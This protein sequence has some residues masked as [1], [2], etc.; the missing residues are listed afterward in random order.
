MYL[1]I[2]ILT[3]H[4]FAGDVERPSCQLQM[5]AKSQL[6]PAVCHST[7]AHSQDCMLYQILLCFSLL[8]RS[9]SCVPLKSAHHVMGLVSRDALA[10]DCKENKRFVLRSPTTPLWTPE[11]CMKT[12]ITAPLTENSLR[13]SRSC[14][15]IWQQDND[16]VMRVL[17][18]L[19]RLIHFMFFSYNM[20][21]A[22]EVGGDEDDLVSSKLQ[23]LVNVAVF[24]IFFL[25]VK[26]HQSY[27]SIVTICP[28]FQA[29]DI[30][31]STTNKSF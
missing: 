27:I 21:D 16:L 10:S 22:W 1:W 17:N 28:P 11:D 8:R 26:M 30:P 3:Q 18:Y 7:F 4:S 15:S 6:A 23:G 12:P 9:T 19:L 25:A 31:R 14:C 24:L 2:S 13:A 20:E 5:L 29:S